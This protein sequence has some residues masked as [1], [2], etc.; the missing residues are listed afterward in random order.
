M[1]K[2]L[3]YRPL[4]LNMPEMPQKQWM[5]KYE[6]KFKTPSSEILL[7]TTVPTVKSKK[8]TSL[9]TSKRKIQQDYSIREIKD[10]TGVGNSKA[11]T[12]TFYGEY[13]LAG[14]R[15]VRK[16]EFDYRRKMG[17]DVCIPKEELNYEC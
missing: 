10:M 1:K 6:I 5:S 11:Y 3:H 14:K 2:Q 7:A 16:D 15:L 4:L 17:L 8:S 9:R 12:N 13:L